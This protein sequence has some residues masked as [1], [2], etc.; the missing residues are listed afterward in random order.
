MKACV[1]LSCEGR[2]DDGFH[3][4]SGVSNIILDLETIKHKEGFKDLVM[5]LDKVPKL[6]DGA[7]FNNNVISNTMYKLYQDGYI[8]EVKYKYI[9]QFYSFHMRC[10]LILKIKLKD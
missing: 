2:Q 10:G 4:C 7:C 6:F 8:S 3:F 1:E 5:Y 9:T